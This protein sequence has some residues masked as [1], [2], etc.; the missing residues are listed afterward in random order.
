LDR[1]LST[2]AV[3][4]QIGVETSGGKLFTSLPATEVIRPLRRIVLEL[5]N[6]SVNVTQL[7]HKDQQV[8][9]VAELGADLPNLTK[10][11][12]SSRAVDEIGDQDFKPPPSAKP[13]AIPRPKPPAARRSLIPRDCHLTVSN[14]KIAEISKELRTLLLSEHPHAISVLFR[15]F[16]EQSVDHYLDGSIFL[17]KIPRQPALEIKI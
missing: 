7:K 6:E 11:A 3:R 10:K 14:T 13:K 5:A 16:L 8:K 17:F 1:L 15:V 4:E 9:W 12:V 2:P